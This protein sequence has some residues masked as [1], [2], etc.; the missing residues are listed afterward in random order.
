MEESIS[1]VTVRSTGI[2][3]GLILAFISIILFLIYMFAGV[4]MSGSARY[5][6]FPIYFIIIYLAHKYFKEN[7]DGFMTFGQG[8]GIA[9]WMGLLSSVISSIFT[10]FYIKV[11]DGSMMQQ[12][13]DKQ[14]E[15]MQEQ[16]I[17]DEQIEQAM[18]MSAPFMSA[19]AILIMGIIFGIIFMVIAGLIVSIFTQK[20]NPEIAY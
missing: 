5:W 2:R 16:G 14:M 15:A 9:F 12:M 11:I 1:N 13:M 19:E 7:G 17:S 3:Y 10:Y 20:K 18:K 6:S 4:D 8:V